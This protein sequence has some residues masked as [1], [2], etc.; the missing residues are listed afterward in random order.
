VFPEATHCC[1]AYHLSRNIISNYK[2]NF[3]AVKRA[4][5]GAAYAYTLDDFNHHMEIVYKAN[6]GARTYL[7]NIRFEKWSRIHC[8]SNR[9]LV[10]TSNVAESINSAL[11]AARD[12]HI[13]VLLD[14]VRGMQQKWNLRNQKEAEC[15]F[16]KLA[17]LGQ[18]MLEENY[19]E[20]MRFTVS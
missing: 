13:T 17:K 19:Q 15:T 2:V 3:E 20:S 4:F 16:T 1:C 6:K 9:F 14:S 10:M 7:T 8:K 11:K 12:L 5:F 18:K